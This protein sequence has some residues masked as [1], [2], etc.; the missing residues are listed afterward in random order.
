ME[1]KATK[2]KKYSELLVTLKSDACSIADDLDA[3]QFIYNNMT[4]T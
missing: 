1:L 4:H 3:E 2:I